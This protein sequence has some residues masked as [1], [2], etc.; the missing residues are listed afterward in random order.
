MSEFNV[1]ILGCGSAKPSLRHHPSCTVV[2]HRGLLFMVD[3]G[4]GAQLQFQ[5]MR[6]KMTRL[7][8]IFLTHLHGDHVFGLPGLAG[9]LALCGKT[10]GITIHTTAE[11]EHILS[12]IF[13]AFNRD[14][15]FDI[16]FNVLDPTRE[17]IAF[18]NR[19]L[20]VRTVPL[21]HRIPTVGY[22]FEEKDKPRHIIREMIDFHHVPFSKINGIKAGEDFV[23][24]DG[25]VI[26]NEALT[27]P[28]DDALSYAHISDTRY[29]PSLAEKIEGA[30][31]LFHETTYLEENMREAR[32]RYHST[33]RQ[34]AMVARDAHAGTLVTGHY[35]SRYRDDSRFKTEAKTV[36]PRVILGNERLT[37]PITR[38]LYGDDL[39]SP[40]K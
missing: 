6:L 9:T 29:M 14:E 22:V 25:R 20:R 13:A 15:D 19:G 39:P 33:A 10:G 40:L 31:L 28:A 17:E 2:E 16:R 24:D 21:N 4:E 38:E 34:A 5:R 37:I 23:T 32:L 1:N 27:K 35:S 30:T 7:G 8:H 26:P 3:C 12:Q 36:F 11:G 18:E